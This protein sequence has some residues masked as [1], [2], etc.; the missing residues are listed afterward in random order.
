MRY[1]SW[2]LLIV[3]ILHWLV[4]CATIRE[5]GGPKPSFDIEKDLQ[6][7][8]TVFS[9]AV[10]ISNVYKDGVTKKKRDKM[11]AG[12]LVMM[13]LRYL[14][15]I[16]SLNAEKQFIDSATD[17]VILSLNIAG[18]ALTPTT[19]RTVLSAISATLSGSK[20]VVDKHYYY[21]KTMPALIAAMNAQR[22]QVLVSIIQGVGRPI[23]LYSVEQAI[24]DLD[25]YYHAGTLIGAVNAIQAT[26]S[27]QEKAS[28]ETIEGITRA[29]VTALI[30]SQART[31]VKSI[32][33]AIEGLTDLDK[34]RTV[35]TELG[36]KDISFDDLSKAKRQLR[37]VLRDRGHDEMKIQEM[38]SIFQKNTM[39]K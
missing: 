16:K 5:G 8:E 1:F 22:K 28:D 29:R 15:F 19:T 26:A 25:T 34:A 38:Y 30:S 37:A 31:Q 11:I 9:S 36:I 14:Q 3:V 4:G 17:I 13:N 35:L 27:S 6:A 10:A 32:G 18:T 12:R 20:V 23:E 39:V 2:A 21:E 24:V 7:L 33:D